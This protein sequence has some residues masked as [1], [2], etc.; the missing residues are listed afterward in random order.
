[1]AEMLQIALKTTSESACC[2]SPY[3]LHTEH[4]PM[5]VDDDGVM[6]QPK[7]TLQSEQPNI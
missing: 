7:T 3:W 4:S 6:N 2:L 5:H 1:M